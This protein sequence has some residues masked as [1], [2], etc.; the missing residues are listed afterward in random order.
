MANFNI[1]ISN[2]LNTFGL[3][4]SDKW[5]S[6]NWNAFLW[7]EG[8]MDLQTILNLIVNTSDILVDTSIATILQINSIIDNALSLGADM[9]RETLTDGSGYAYVFGSDTNIENKTSTS[10]S[11]VSPVT[12]TWTPRAASSTS[13]R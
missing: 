11:T 3:A 4:E 6:Y 7:G 10:Y 1:T 13:W 2:S 8:T 12:T 9:S 5:G